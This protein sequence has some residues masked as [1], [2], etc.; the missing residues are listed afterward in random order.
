MGAGKTTLGKALAQRVGLE[1]VDTDRVLVERTGVPVATIF[2]IEGE[3][4]F[5]GASRASSPSSR[6]GRAAWSPPGAARCSRGQPPRDARGRHRD[7]PARALS[8]ALWERTAATTSSRPLLATPDPRATLAR[9][10]E[11]RDP[12]YRD[13]AHLIVETG[14]QSAGTS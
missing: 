10:L 14:S 1:F 9:L 7:L 8:S 6:A 5:R 4:G 2:E 11:E 3:D 13:A 12:L